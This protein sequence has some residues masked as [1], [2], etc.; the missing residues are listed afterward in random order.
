MLTLFIRTLIIYI[1]LVIA[2]RMGG[3][4]Q[5]GELQIS[6]LVTALLLS[7]IAA[8]PIG[9]EEIPLTYAVVPILT[10]IS[11]E[12]ICAFIVTKSQPLKRLFDGTPSVLIRK[13]KLDKAELGRA[14]M[15]LEELLSEARLKGISDISD[16]E[17]AILEQNGKLSVFEKA[18]KGEKETG[19]A[20]A[21]IVDGNVSEHGLKCISMTRDDLDARLKNKKTGL[22]KVFLYTVNDAGE[23][24]WIFRSH[25]QD[26]KAGY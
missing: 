8:L 20:H 16:L 18:K 10:V 17:Y 26:G 2:M 22:D 3:K 23:E 7:E 19:I 14:R 1:F 13:G 12:I 9:H 4:R 5:I 6:E 11:V 25:K 15:G 24:N 21:V